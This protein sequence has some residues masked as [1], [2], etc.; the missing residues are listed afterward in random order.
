M[1]TGNTAWV[2][3]STALVLFMTPGL[4]LLLRR[5]GPRQERARHA[6]AELLRHG[7]A[8]RSSGSAIGFTPRLRQLRRRRLDR[9]LRLRLAEGRRPDRAGPDGLRASTIPFILFCAFQMTF[10]DHHAGADH[11]RHRRPPEVR[12]L[13]RVHRR[14]AGA[15]LRP[16]RPLGV[17]RRLA[18]R[19][20]RARLRR[21]RGRAHQRRRR[22]PRPWCS[23]S[24]SAGAGP[25]EPMP[26]AQPAAAPCSA[27]ASCGS[28]GSA[29][30][31]A[32]RSAA[33]GVAAQALMNT[34]LAASAAHAR[35]ARSSSASRTG[36]PPPSAPPRVRSPAWS[37]SPRAPASSAACRRSSSASSPASSATSPSR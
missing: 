16:G 36:T 11:R 27:P 26:P 33:N 5:H 15:R 25:D 22:R 35:L 10:A 23:C 32:R 24:A 31:P 18:R 13:R 29:S 12:G 6:H 19:A 3:I 14:L 9:Q 30:T 37:P 28:A 4:A 7:P 8:R 17:R 21:R 1:D 34:F 20:G 2:L